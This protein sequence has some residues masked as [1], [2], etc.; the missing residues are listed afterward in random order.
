M[1]HGEAGTGATSSGVSDLAAD[2]GDMAVAA[3]NDNMSDVETT[4]LQAKVRLL[5]NRLAAN[6]FA[7]TIGGSSRTSVETMLGALAEY[8]AT[9]G[10]AI[11]ATVD[12]GGTARANLELILEDLGKMLAGSG[13]ITTWP[14]AANIG[15]GVS[16]AEGVRAILT[17]LVGDDDFDGYTNLSN[18]AVTS[19]DAAVQALAAVLGCD[20]ANT[21]SV[22]VNGGTSTTLESALTALSTE[23]NRIQPAMDFWSDVADNVT[24][25]NAAGDESLPNVVVADLPTGATVVRAILMLKIRKIK[26]SSG[27]INYIESA[28]KIR[29]DSDV[30]LGSEVDAIDIPSS[31]LH[32]EADGVEGGDVIIGDND[33]AAEVTGNGTYYVTWESADAHG[34][35]LELYDVQVGLRIWYAV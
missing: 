2:L 21:F 31:A 13:G 5:L 10:A 24:I 32:T 9:S 20:G 8:F 25:T 22:T 18:A 7:A 26:D 14:A 27:A 33:V 30:G 6:S 29:I 19:L 15:D 35:N 23:I 1:A 11:S 16:I 12:P 34:A 4:S 28:Q 17:S 3:T